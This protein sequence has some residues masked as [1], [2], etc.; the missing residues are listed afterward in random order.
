MKKT[1]TRKLTLG[2]LIAA[3]YVVL[4]LLQNLLL[5]GSASMS[6]QFRVS[7]AL[8]VLTLFTPSAIWGLSL[9]CLLFN[10]TF[11]STLPLDWFVGTAATALS[12]MAMYQM[13][14]LRIKK[15]PFLSLLM[16][17]VMNGLL[18]G[19]ELTVYIKASP[20]WVN[21]LCVA[22]GELAV[23]FTLGAALYFALLPVKN[24]LFNN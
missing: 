1:H 24:R 11:G 17:A 15:L 14:N 5:P 21:I 6:I 7:E 12:A 22:A 23:L 3:L 4:T 10:L 8:C 20:L 2:A 9:G 18:V 13:R 19:A 16:P